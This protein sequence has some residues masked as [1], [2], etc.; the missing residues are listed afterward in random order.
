MVFLP[1]SCALW[2]PGR[3]P[4][5]YAMASV[6]TGP[7]VVLVFGL[8]KVLPFDPLFAGVTVSGLIMAAGFSNRRRQNPIN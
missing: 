1:L 8:W 7:L 4:T 6:L 3:I 2:L 5:R